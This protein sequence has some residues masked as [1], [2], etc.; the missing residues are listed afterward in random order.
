MSTKVQILDPEKNYWNTIREAAHCLAEGGLVAFRTETVY[1]LGANAASKK[2]IGRLRAVKERPPGKPFTVHIGQRTDVER[3]VPIVPPPARRLIDKAWPGPLTLILPVSDPKSAA[4]FEDHSPE[5]VPSMYHD[6]TI[7]IRYPDDQAALDLLTEARIPVVAAS[8]NPA[9]RPAP[10]EPAEVLEHLDG[11]IDLLIDAGR[12]RYTKPSTIVR[13]DEKG[14]DIVRE[15]VL[16]SRTIQRLSNVN[17]LLV[18]SGNTCRSPMAEGLLKQ[19]LADELGCSIEALAD[20]GYI[21]ESAGTSAF[22]GAPASQEA[23]AVLNRRGIDLTAHR[24]QPLTADQVQRADFILTMTSRHADAVGMQAPAARS[25]VASLD[26][27]DVED[28]VGCDEETYARCASQ[29]EKALQYRLKE[30][31][32]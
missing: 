32:T 30:I 27:T 24:S 20:R 3:F 2:A 21:V 18:C 14:Y 15:G 22:P 4:V 19:M 26:Q 1:G 7:G 31:V 16:D 23:I 29:I 8:A 17:I 11:Q 13:V 25:K 9:G 10:V 5:H 6:G 12:T 28:P